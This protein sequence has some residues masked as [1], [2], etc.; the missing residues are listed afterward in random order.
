V[1][2]AYGA[3][4]RSAPDG[5]VDC[6][7][8]ADV[9]SS[10]TADNTRNLVMIVVTRAGQDSPAWCTT[11]IEASISSDS[12]HQVLAEADVL[13]SVGSR[14]DSYGQRDGRGTQLAVSKTE[15]IRNPGDAIQGRH[16]VL[17]DV[18]IAVE[19]YVDWFN[20][21]HLRGQIGLVTARR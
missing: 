19:E 3:W 10:A 12:P 16:H 13:A 18:E 17:S 1:A 21:R 14:G 20:Q 8:H 2:G 6:V 7:Q 9:S 11:Q 5:R 4:L 15:C